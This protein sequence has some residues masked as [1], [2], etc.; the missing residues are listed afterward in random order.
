MISPLTTGSG[1]QG[2]ER[3]SRCGKKP[4]RVFCCN[5]LFFAVS[6]ST[7]PST[8]AP[9]RGWAGSQT[10]MSA[11][12]TLYKIPTTLRKNRANLTPAAIM[13]GLLASC[14][15][16]GIQPRCQ[17]PLVRPLFVSFLSACMVRNFEGSA[18]TYLAYPTY[19]VKP[20]CTH[21]KA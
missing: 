14:V 5:L 2:L 8:R 6:F 7:S 21:V 18:G 9:A 1:V 20:N 13:K 19:H 12:D 15:I 11:V 16:A 10:Q 17:R 3:R 4:A